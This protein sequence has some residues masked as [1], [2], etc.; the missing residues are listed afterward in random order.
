[1]TSQS[2]S[3]E[4]VLS[5]W[6]GPLPV[7]PQPRTMFRILLEVGIKRRVS[8]ADLL[9]PSRLQEHVRPRHEAMW[10]MRQVT[11]ADGSQRYSL[12]TI[13]RFFNRDHTTVLSGVRRHAE[14]IG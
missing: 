13:G 4:T 2:Q 10:A 14:R 1:M 5:L 6:R 9:G 8:T 7:A 12:P 11:W 3:G